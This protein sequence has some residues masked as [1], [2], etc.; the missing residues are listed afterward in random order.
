MKLEM[1][2]VDGYFVK[3]LVGI[4]PRGMHHGKQRDG[5]KGR[6]I[7]EKNTSSSG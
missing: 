4:N 7:F 2:T 1:N 5:L 6:N 3:K